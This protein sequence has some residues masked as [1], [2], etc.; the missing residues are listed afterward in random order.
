MAKYKPY[1]PKVGPGGIG[2]KENPDK[3]TVMRAPTTSERVWD[4]TEP[5]RN[6]L[7]KVKNFAL[8]ETPEEELRNQLMPGSMAATGAAGAVFVPTPGTLEAIRVLEKLYPGIR[9]MFGRELGV[10]SDRIPHS[11]LNTPLEQSSWG[12]NPKLFYRDDA[13]GIEHMFKKGGQALH[14]AAGG[15]VVAEAARVGGARHL[16]P[17]ALPAESI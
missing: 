3:R 6:I 9:Q 14:E 13:T 15:G 7:S 11:A 4:S 5:L 17:L 12:S 10:A 2:E 16:P 1:I 8:G